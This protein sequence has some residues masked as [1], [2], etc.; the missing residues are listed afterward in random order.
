MM[1]IFKEHH[2][3]KYGRKMELNFLRI[4]YDFLAY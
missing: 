4:S 1:L 2:A 3:E